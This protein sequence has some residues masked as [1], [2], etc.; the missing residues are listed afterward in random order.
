MLNDERKKSRL[1]NKLAKALK[2][3]EV[4]PKKVH[5][6]WFYFYSYYIFY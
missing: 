6:I 1:A 2:T 5:I 4:A 3:K